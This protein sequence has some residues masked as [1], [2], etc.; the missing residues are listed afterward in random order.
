MARIHPSADVDPSA[1][2]A[3]GVEIGP[4]CMVGPSVRL[5]ENCRLLSH[6]AVAGHTT[7]GPRTVVHPHASLG[8]PPQSTGY[9]G[10]PTRL[11]IGADCDI[12]ESVTINVGTE[13]GRGV[14]AVGDRGFFMAYSHVGHDCAVGSDAVFANG[15]TLGGHC[16]IGD[17]VF[18]GG[19]TTLHQFTK[20]GSHA[21]VGGSSGLNAQV[22]PFAMVSGAPARIIG[23]NAVGMKR[24]GFASETVAL[25]RR[26]IRAL[27]AGSAPLAERLACL[28]RDFGDDPA[29][30]QIL[31]FVKARGKRPLAQP[32]RRS[33]EWS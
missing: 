21:M 6:V 4:F 9:R 23:V 26:A 20:V 18:I 14:T 13:D 24:R 10:G 12:R 32:S 27:F 7:I 1:E 19:L 22:I 28:E 15:A 8:G 29:V 5:G 30:A 2:I 33:G 25:V 31:S 17:F 16:D 11:A 3:E